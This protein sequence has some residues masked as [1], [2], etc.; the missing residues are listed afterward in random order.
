MSDYPARALINLAAIQRNVAALR[1]RATAP[2]MAVVKADA[3]G[4]G[5]VPSARA[6]LAGGATWLGV[7]QLSEALDLRAA[8]VDA[9]L[10]TWIYAPGAPL[11]R[12][13]R[14]G[15]D[16]SVGAPWAL[17]EVRAAV[18]ATGRTARIHLKVDTG[19]GRGGQFLPAWRDML[20]QALRAQAAGEVEVVGVWSHLASAEDVTSATT[21]SQRE[22]F[23]EAV[24]LAEAGGAHLELRHLANSAATLVRPDLHF[25]LVRPGL[26]VFGLSPLPGVSAGEVGLEP[27]MRLEASLMVVKHAPA[28]QG[29]SYGHTY[30]TT[31]QTVLADVPLGYA[32]G[33]PRH[34]GSAGPVQVA[35]RRYTIAGRVC[36]DQFVLDLGADSSAAAGDVAVLFGAGTDGEPT[37]QDWAEAAGTISYEIVT[38]LG[39]RVPRVHHRDGAIQPTTQRTP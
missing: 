14:A 30:T 18:A 23:L 19:L 26:A 16:L 34:A 39:V 12:A 5:L 22:V 37:A 15:I 36:M 29:V 17:A 25:D 21:A 3:Y 31:A 6:A 27:A 20:D 24:A 7:A 8:G 35:G 33:I 13:V 9:P 2:V 4:H 38:R 11:A 32:D 1:E 28:G 10:L